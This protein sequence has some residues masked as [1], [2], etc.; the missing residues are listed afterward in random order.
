MGDLFLCLEG[1]YPMLM[2]SESHPALVAICPFF[3]SDLG[4]VLWCVI[5]KITAKVRIEI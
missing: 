4:P 2:V 5:L 1:E 3:F